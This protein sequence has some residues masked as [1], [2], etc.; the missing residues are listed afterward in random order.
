MKTNRQEK[1][2][3]LVNDKKGEAF[4]R[5]AKDPNPTCNTQNQDF[6]KNLK[7]LINENTGGKIRCIALDL[8]RTTLRTDGTMSARTREALLAAVDNGIEVLP[9]SGRPFASL[10]KSI[11]CLSGIRYVAVSNGAAV[12]DEITGEKIGGWTI[13]SSDVEAI[14][15]MTETAFY[16]GEV[17]YEVFINGIAWADQAYIKNPV[18]YGIPERAVAYTRK[19]RH[20]VVD[21]CSFIRKHKTEL[22]SI[23]IMLKEPSVRKTLD[24]ELRS[25]IP[26]IYTT[27]SVEYRLEISHKEASKAS[28][29]SLMLQK[30]GIL[31]KE[32]IAFGDGDNDA[33]MLKFA[34]IGVAV[35]N[36][37][38]DCLASADL[39]S[40][41]NDADGVAFI[42]EKVLC[43]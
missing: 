31:P 18:A 43:L 13:E 32:T 33:D 23:D 29:L 14:L 7:R 8:D 38:P 26:G 12:Y 35:K 19:T 22:E 1:P 40:E 30:L 9:V 36:A 5:S 39:V 37:T 2:L 27:S 42:I 21:I 24:Q 6:E 34:G 10:P 17:T 25:A 3:S 16:E 4:E 11:C 15:Q 20:P 41:S 28:G